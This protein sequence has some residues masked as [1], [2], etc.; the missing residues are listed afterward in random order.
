ML[1]PAALFTAMP[2]LDPALKV[3][4]L[5]VGQG[6]SAMIE[7]PHRRAVYVIDTGGLL[8]FGT[9]EFRMKERPFEIGR[10]VVVP[11]LKGKGISSVD[12]LVLSHADADHAEGADELFKALQIRNLHLTPGSQTTPLMQELA[13]DAS[14]AKLSYPI[15]GSGWMEGQTRFH[16]L[17]PADAEYSGNDDSLVMLLENNGFRVL[18][19]GDLEMAGEKKIVEAYSGELAGLTILKIGHHGSKTSSGQ[20]FLEAAMPNLS[21]FSTGKDNR[22]GHP[23]PDVVERFQDLN[24][25]VLNTAESGTIEVEVVDG[26]WELRK[27]R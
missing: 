6:D 20:E 15:S 27:M 19:T 13:K 1:V 24:L 2:Y 9:E 7:L 21:I 17:S 25:P 26:E 10:Q 22:Y 23:N 11:Y 16:Y 12:L 4:F 5:D 14:E 3:T 18:F 8:R